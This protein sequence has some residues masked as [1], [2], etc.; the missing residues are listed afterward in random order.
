M[1][2]PRT[3]LSIDNSHHYCNKLAAAHGALCFYMGILETAVTSCQSFC[4][5]KWLLSLRAG[6]LEN[7]V[8]V[9]EVLRH[10][11]LNVDWNC[12]KIEAEKNIVLECLKSSQ[13]ISRITFQLQGLAEELDLIGASFMKMDCE[14]S[15]II[16]AL[17]LSCSLFAFTA[18]FC[19]FS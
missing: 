19:D 8:G 17:A 9:I 4:S 7:V 16:A 10:V 11:P 6:V 14:C 12:S 15:T 18:G 13:E 5:Q 1:K 2:H 3:A